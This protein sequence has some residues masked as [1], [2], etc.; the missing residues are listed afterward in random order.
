MA[1]LLSDKTI[2]GEIKKKF[3]GLSPEQQKIF[4]KRTDTGWF[5]SYARK[6]KIQLKKIT[7]KVRKGI[8]NGHYVCKGAKPH[9][10]PRGWQGGKIKGVSESKIKKERAKIKK[11]IETTKSPKV[12][13]RL[14]SASKRYPDASEYEL[15]YGVNSGMSRRYRMRKGLSENYEGRVIERRKK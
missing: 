15:R 11:H 10:P 6:S 13:K 3:T 2:D 8:A 7:D 5:R 4:T 9:A 12:K 1:K 14:I